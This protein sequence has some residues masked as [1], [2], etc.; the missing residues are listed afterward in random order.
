MH[1]RPRPTELL[2][3]VN[4]TSRIVN[5]STFSLQK[6]FHLSGIPEHTLKD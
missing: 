3:K 1:R 4:T 6:I 5:F 2:H